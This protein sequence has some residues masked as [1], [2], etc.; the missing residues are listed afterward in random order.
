MLYNNYFF[1]RNPATQKKKN[2]TNL[3][4]PAYT[5]FRRDMCG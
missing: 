1:I 4:K 5:E 2:N 3:V